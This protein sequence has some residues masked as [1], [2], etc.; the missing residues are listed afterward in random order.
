MSC[1]GDAVQFPRAARTNYHKSS[2]LNQEKFI[3]SQFGCQKSQIQVSAGP[4]SLKGSGG[5]SIV[6]FIFWWL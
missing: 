6:R 4:C 5:Q 3:P 1:I 2:G